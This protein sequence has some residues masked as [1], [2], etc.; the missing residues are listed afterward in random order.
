MA[1][2][3][4]YKRPK[5]NPVFEHFAKDQFHLGSNIP[6]ID[7]AYRSQANLNLLNG[8]EENWALNH[9]FTGA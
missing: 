2:L 7:G 6:V 9:K 4:N 1:F 5:R 3:Y 8:N